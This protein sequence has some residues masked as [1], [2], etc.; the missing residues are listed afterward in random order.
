MK[1]DG[2]REGGEGE[3]GITMIQC[4]TIAVYIHVQCTMYNAV[5]TGVY[6][7]LAYIPVQPWQTRSA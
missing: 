1:G 4:N 3:G 5:H 2:G 6:T 7:C